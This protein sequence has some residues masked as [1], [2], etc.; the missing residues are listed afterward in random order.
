MLCLY[1]P[2]ASLK[3]WGEG[4]FLGYNFFLPAKGEFRLL[5]VFRLGLNYSV[6]ICPIRKR[7]PTIDDQPCRERVSGRDDNKTC[8]EKRR[9]NQDDGQKGG[10]FLF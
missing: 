2:F 1:H 5:A 3:H 6:C 10:V 4:L 7:N 9:E 8:E